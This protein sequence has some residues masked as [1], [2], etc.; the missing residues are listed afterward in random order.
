M[1]LGD[2]YI[3]IRCL[4]LSRFTACSSLAIVRAKACDVFGFQK[5]QRGHSLSKCETTS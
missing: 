5:I 3:V 2:M 4:M 1:G